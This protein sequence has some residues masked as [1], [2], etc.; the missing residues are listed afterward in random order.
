MLHC[1]AAHTKVASQ[2]A[3]KRP[4]HHR[5]R[6]VEA[7][8]SATPAG[9]AAVRSPVFRRP[10]RRRHAGTAEPAIYIATP[11]VVAGCQ[12]PI[13][14]PQAMMLAHTRATLAPPA[15]CSH[16]ATATLAPPCAANA[17]H[18]RAQAR[19]AT[20]LR[21]PQRGVPDHNM[22][23]TQFVPG[24]Q[25]IGRNACQRYAPRPHNTLKSG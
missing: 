20:S 23:Q 16:S 8:I 11:E 5:K 10:G 21:K 17:A 22:V 12:L 18:S 24:F 4:P 15:R 13:A 19:A 9:V 2:G 6:M 25:E 7:D 3:A 14:K 1:A